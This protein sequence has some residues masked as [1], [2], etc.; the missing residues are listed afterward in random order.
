MSILVSKHIF[1]ATS[2]VRRI[3]P[4]FNQPMK[5]RMWPIHQPLDQSVFE[6]I[7]MDVIHMG[8]KIRLIANQVLPISA[9]PNAPFVARHA[10][11]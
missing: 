11:Q 9:L 8:A 5:S 10:N 2:P 4:L 7:D 1:I 3:I 6:R